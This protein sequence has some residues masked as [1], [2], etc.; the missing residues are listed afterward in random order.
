[1]LSRRSKWL[2]TSRVCTWKSD[3][4]TK[5]RFGRT[6]LVDFCPI[7]TRSWVG[8][9]QG[10]APLERPHF[11]RFLDAWR[12]GSDSLFYHSLSFLPAK[13]VHRTIVG[14]PPNGMLLA[15]LWLT[16][17]VGKGRLR[18]IFPWRPIRMEATSLQGGQQDVNVGASRSWWH[19][20]SARILQN[21][22]KS[23]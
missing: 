14:S 13:L 7:W 3:L 4:A 11:D 8:W 2:G 16:G 1:M 15:L 12:F 17:H 20:E 22:Q 10:I 9:R 21:L 18:A 19:S 23:T 6:A 5:S